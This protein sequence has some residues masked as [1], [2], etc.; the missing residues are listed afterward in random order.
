M[1]TF[2]FA[3][4]LT[5]GPPARGYDDAATQLELAR[6]AGSSDDHARAIEQLDQAITR[7]TA[8]P[9]RLAS[10][11]RAR[12]LLA[13]ARMRLAWHH[14]ANNDHAR[15]EAVMDAALRAT[16]GELSPPRAYGPALT[17]LYTTHH[18]RLEQLGRARVEVV[19]GV[20]CRVIIDERTIDDPDDPL[21]AHKARL[22]A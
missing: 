2:L 13:D 1:H 18:A 12:A 14:L 22:A 3:L 7:I 5:I 16:N 4:T 9:E 10:D 19:C 17:K 11:E 8:F 21:Y 20:P 15:A 6:D